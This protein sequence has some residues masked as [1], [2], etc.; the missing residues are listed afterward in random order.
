MDF[1][2]PVTCNKALTCGF[3]GL[4]LTN[5]M[6]QGPNII[7]MDL[8]WPATWPRLVIFLDLGWPI[9]CNK[10][11]TCHFH[12]LGLTSY[13]QH[14]PDFWFP[15]TKVDQLHATRPWLACDF[16]G[17]GLTSHMQQGPDLWFP[18]TWVDQSHATRP[19]LVISMVLGWQVTCNMA[20]TF[21]FHGLR[22]TCYMQQGPDLRFSMD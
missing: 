6:Q 8:G 9:T 18:W 22:L 11:R 3:R 16:H 5:Y 2:W 1:G 19:W 14:G 10:A 13:M 17:L 21:G 20:L 12:G 4:R 7:F 15:W